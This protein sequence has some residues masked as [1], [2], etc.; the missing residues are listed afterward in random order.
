MKLFFNPE[1]RMYKF[2]GRLVDLFF[3]NVLF[4]VASLPIITI[5]A[6]WTAMATVALKIVKEENS[7]IF[8]E[9]WQSFK[10][11]FL[12]GCGLTAVVLIEG[13]LLF[14]TVNAIG[15]LQGVSTIIGLLGLTLLVILIT[16]HWLYLFPYTARYNDSFFHALYVSLQ[17]ALLNLK[18]SFLMLGGV[19]AFFLLMS[20]GSV[21]FALTT[22]VLLFVGFAAAAVMVADI[23]LPI[24]QQYEN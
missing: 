3:L 6:S 19:I 24:F 5:G 14:L 20:L 11:N 22:L 12:R 17:I 8:Q 13:G 18:K 10:D 1:S 21:W 7:S 2:C 15:I 9:F 16:F 4:L 23:S